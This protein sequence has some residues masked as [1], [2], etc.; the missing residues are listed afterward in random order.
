MGVKEAHFLSILKHGLLIL[1]RHTAALSKKKGGN[2][3]TH[4][5]IHRQIPR[6]VPSD[7]HFL[8]L[9]ETTPYVAKILN[10]YRYS[11]NR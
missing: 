6:V 8:G 1:A 4:K 7:L 2:D 9:N 3:I 11:L 5:H 10:L